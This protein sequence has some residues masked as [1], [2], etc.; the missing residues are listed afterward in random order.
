MKIMCLRA[1]QLE[2]AISVYSPAR[3]SRSGHCVREDSWSRTRRV[4]SS[5]SVLGRS[6]V[7]SVQPYYVW[8]FR[9]FLCLTFF[10]VSLLC[11]HNKIL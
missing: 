8:E 1:R 5:H 7:S 4:R 2:I 6:T 9:G 3:G 11:N 10:V